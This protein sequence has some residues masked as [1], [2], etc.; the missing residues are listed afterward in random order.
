MDRAS[1]AVEQWQ[2]ERP[3]IDGLVMAVFGRL[4]EAAQRVARDHLN[5]LFQA[6]GLGPGEFDVLATL[7]RSGAPYALSP[8]ALYDATMVTSGA[9]TGRIDRLQKAGWVVRTP[10]PEDRR[11]VLVSLTD[12]G[13]ALIDEVVTLHV[14]NETQLLAGLSQGER[15]TLAGLLGK[16]LATLPEPYAGPGS[17]TRES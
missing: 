1:L 15:E 2:R 8:T 3:E 12:A 6:H 17:Q 10:D 13:R 7:R 11:G 14:A 4:A 9:M 5:P 16:L